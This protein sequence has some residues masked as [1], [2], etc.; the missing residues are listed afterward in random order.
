MKKK[1]IIPAM[2]ATAIRQQ[3]PLT[4]SG[5]KGP[6]ACDQSDP[7]MENS[8]YPSGSRQSAWDEEDDSLFP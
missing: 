4:G 7:G 6:S 1:Y 8:N 3:Q 2:Q 5:G